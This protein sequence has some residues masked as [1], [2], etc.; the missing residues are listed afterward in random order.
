[1]LR[2]PSKQLMEKELTITRS[3]NA[4]LKNAEI[5]RFP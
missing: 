4:L 1:M 3:K 5:V 2:A